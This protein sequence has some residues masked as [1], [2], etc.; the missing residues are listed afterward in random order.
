M[1]EEPAFLDAKQVEALHKIALERHGGQD[2]FV[3]W[4]RSR[5]R[6]CSPA[7]S[8]TTPRAISLM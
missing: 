4:R 2:G 1:S 8:S 3:I 6:S 7:T 5:A